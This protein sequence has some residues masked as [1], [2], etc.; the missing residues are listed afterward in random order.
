MTSLRRLDYYLVNA[1][2]TGKPASG[3]QAAVVVF[4]NATDQRAENDDFLLRTAQN[5]G[6]AETAYLVPIDA[7]QGKWGLRWFTVE[8]VSIPLPGL[9]L[10]AW[11]AARSFSDFE[12]TD[13]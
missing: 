5:F 2:S 10:E 9:T 13:I 1:F 3:N 6:F 4:G 8:V 12:L 7:E 11:P